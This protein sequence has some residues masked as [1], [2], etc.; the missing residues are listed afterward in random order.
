MNPMIINLVILLIGTSIAA[1]T[2]Y[3]SGIVPDK[4]SHFMIISGVILAP[5]VYTD[6]LFVYGVAAIVFGLGF[7]MYSFGQLGGGD[8]KLFTAIALLVPYYPK[9]MQPIVGYIGISPTLPVY[10]FIGSVFIL[11]GLIGPM[12]IIPLKNHYKLF[13]NKDKVPKFSKKIR[14]GL[15]LILILIPLLI[16][17]FSL[18]PAFIVIFIPMGVTMALLPFKEDMIRLFYSE[19]KFIKD[20]NDD[21]VLA[22]EEID[23]KIKEDLNLWRKTFTPPELKKIK[24]K[25]E[26]KGYEKIK[27]CENLPIFVPYILLAILVNL[28][29]GDAFFYLVRLTI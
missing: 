6:L 9:V 8:V 2:D 24:K 12:F 25:A 23:E 18:A 16:L 21:D 1:Y 11:A 7:A 13:K 19:E 4:L 3:K 5:I 20:L 29:L 26:E 28:F 27:V 15:I 10:P 14:R 22:L 17:W